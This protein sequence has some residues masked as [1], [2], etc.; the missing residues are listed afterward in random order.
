MSR[1]VVSSDLSKSSNTKLKAQIQESPQ[2][3]PVKSPCIS[4]CALDSEG[5]CTGC[6]R[7]GDEIRLWGG[8]TNTQR[9]DVLD[10]AH[11]REKKVNPFL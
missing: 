6:F 5:M 2:E 9:R 3:Q 1:N 11:E 10:L 8:Y 7:T 4:V